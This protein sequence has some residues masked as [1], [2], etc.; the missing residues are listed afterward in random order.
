M[1]I[2]E[3]ADNRLLRGRKRNALRLPPLVA[4]DMPMLNSLAKFKVFWSLGSWRTVPSSSSPFPLGAVK[5]LV[6]KFECMRLEHSNSMSRIFG[7]LDL[8]PTSPYSGHGDQCYQSKFAQVL[9]CFK[10]CTLSVHHRLLRHFSS[11]SRPERI[12][13]LIEKLSIKA[14]IFSVKARMPQDGTAE[15]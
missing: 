10:F 12:M 6:Q 3:R 13:S 5:D 11:P 14:R 1:P 15:E 9:H 7:C 8:K 2:L 4:V